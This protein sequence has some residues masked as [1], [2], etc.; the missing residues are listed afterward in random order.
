MEKGP[1]GKW[2]F[3]FTKEEDIDAFINKFPTFVMTLEGHPK[4]ALNCVKRDIEDYLPK[5]STNE[6]YFPSSST[7]G[8]GECLV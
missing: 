8:V 2:Q 6:S 3:F 7:G 5:T 1:K 4:I